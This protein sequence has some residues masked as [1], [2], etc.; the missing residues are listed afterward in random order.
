M[1]SWI[2]GEQMI[3]DLKELMSKSLILLEVK[4]L[5][6][7]MNLLQEGGNF[8]FGMDTNGKGFNDTINEPVNDTFNDD[9]G[10]TGD[11]GDF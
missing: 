7:L 10:T 3:L 11:L 1:T 4:E 6:Q 8:S 9:F 5:E 2:T